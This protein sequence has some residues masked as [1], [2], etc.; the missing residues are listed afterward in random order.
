MKMKNTDGWRCLNPQNL[1]CILYKCP[2]NHF[3][4]FPHTCY[5]SYSRRI[6]RFSDT[7]PLMMKK[8]ILSCYVPF[9]TLEVVTQALHIPF[10]SPLPSATCNITTTII[11]SSNFHLQH[12]HHHHHHHHNIIKLPPPSYY[13]RT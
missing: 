7:L 12:H 6:D 2:N 3:L 10:L 9:K 1:N 11:I 4:H 13:H 8:T 5:G